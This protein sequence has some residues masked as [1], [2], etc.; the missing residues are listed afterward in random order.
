MSP[1][2]T[3]YRADGTPKASDVVLADSPVGAVMAYAGTALTPE[4]MVCDGRAISRAAYPDL[5]A[6]IGTAW[7]A[8]DGSTT[9]NIPD[10]RGATVV[11]AGQGS[12]LTLRALAGKG[13]EERHTLS[14]A[15]MPSHGHP[16]TTGPSGHSGGTAYNGTTFAVFSFSP[17]YVNNGAGAYQYTWSAEAVGG[18]GNHENMPPFAVANWIIRVLSPARVAGVIAPPIPLITSLPTN[19]VDGQEIYFLAD[20]TN[21]IIWHF[22]YRAGSASAYKWEFMG[23]SR[24]QHSVFTREASSSTSAV[25]LATVGPTITVPLAGDYDADIAFHAY[26]SALGGYVSG[27]IKIGAAAAS[28]QLLAIAP[29]S[30]NNDII[31]S[32]Y[33][34]PVN[35]PT[36]GTVVKMMYWVS[37]G[38]GN[39]ERRW[40]TMQPRRVG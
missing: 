13:G 22:R 31:G 35:V 19:P 25:D 27:G 12:G 40:M 36:A 18:G 11:G 17:D 1:G 28:G 14:T 21:S 34:L 23:G 3:V 33:A 7:G 32:T 4:W 16:V 9:F 30:A 39:W 37:G 8:G 10:L 24:L 20:A 5:L 29:G 2:L 26:G 38:T 15:E 6:A